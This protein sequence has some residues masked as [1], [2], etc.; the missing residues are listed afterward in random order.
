MD[1]L[2][3][4]LAGL[5][6]GE[7]L[8]QTKKVQEGLKN[9]SDKPRRWL[10][11]TASLLANNFPD[12]D[13]LYTAITPP[14]LGSLL[15][16]RGHTHTLGGALGLW[17]LIL[18]VLFLVPAFRRV[19]KERTTFLLTGGVIAMGL[20]AHILMDSWNNY[21]VHPFWPFSSDWFYGDAIF[22]IEPV[23]WICLLM[24]LLHTL[25]SKWLRYGLSFI[26][27]GFSFW[28]WTRGFLTWY[29]GAL[30]VVVTLFF[31]FLLKQT[32]SSL[33]KLSYG[34]LGVLVYLGIQFTGSYLLRHRLQMEFQASSAGHEVL[35][36]IAS[37]SPTNPI[38][39]AVI[40]L[41]IDTDKK[42]YLAHSKT[43]SLW[44][45]MVPAESCPV[46]ASDDK[47]YEMDLGKL[48]NDIERDCYLDAWLRFARAPVFEQGHALDI[49]FRG[50][51]NFT[52]LVDAGTNR[53]CPDYIA[54][55]GRPR[56][57][58]M[59]RTE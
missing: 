42:L 25:H 2:T 40:Q 56:Q 14:P 17:L 35:D 16:H 15:H 32:P 5:A 47:K 30:L 43:E 4:S 29:S 26:I 22:I 41:E 19:L 50:E 55:W 24:P 23:I 6:L 8:F 54:K 3:H 45:Q 36:I 39:W 49:R 53:A 57:D 18:A 48:K 59:N 37:P 1:N 20:G 51:R 58:L 33:K 44:P 27:Y 7:S 11:L 12:L 13:L 46:F 28:A 9:E 52:I 38:C 21:G 10:F 31:Y 34:F